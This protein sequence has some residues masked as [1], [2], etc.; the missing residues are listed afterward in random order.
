MNKIHIIQRRDGSLLV[1]AVANP[2]VP[3]DVLYRAHHQLV[4][5]FGPSDKVVVVPY[6][7]GVVS[8]NES[9]WQ[10]LLGWWVGRRVRKAVES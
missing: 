7:T 10:A 1:V 8:T 4:K 9:L 6:A 3:A 2:G 5:A